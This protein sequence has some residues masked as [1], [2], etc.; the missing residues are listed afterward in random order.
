MSSP[1]P[2]PNQPFST[3]NKIPKTDPNATLL[4][5]LSEP[6]R[7]Q[8]AQA[9][10]DAGYKVTVNGKFTQALVEAYTNASQSAAIQ[11]QQL[12]LKPAEVALQKPL[13]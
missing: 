10:K 9:L 6:A 1:T 7:K 13:I 12:G 3:K 11:S 4:Y 2:D 8:V 5:G